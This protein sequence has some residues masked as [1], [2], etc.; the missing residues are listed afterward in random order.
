M[1]WIF[2]G[3]VFGQNV[4]VTV[5]GRVTEAESGQPISNF[6]I[7]IGQPAGF[8]DIL[9]FRSAFTDASG[10]YS[11]NF[12]G[13][14]GFPLK[15]WTD[16][17]RY[18]AYAWPNARFHYDGPEGTAGSFAFTHGQNIPLGAGSPISG[19]DF[20]VT[21]PA[22]LTGRVISQG[23]P[24]A[25]A[26]V[27]IRTG[28]FPNAAI[29]GVS[30]NADGRFSLRRMHPGTGPLEVTK[31]GFLNT[32]Y[33]NARLDGL[34]QLAA[35]QPPQE[36]TL[37]PE[38]ELD[39]ELLVDPGYKLQVSGT[40][41][42]VAVPIN[43]QIRG[44]DPVLGPRPV[45]D[46]ILAYGLDYFIYN[47]ESSSFR[48]VAYP[49][50]P[51]VD[52]P[53]NGIQPF[54]LANGSSPPDIVL[55]LIARQLLHGT[56]RDAAG[57]PLP[58]ARVSRAARFL[59]GFSGNVVRL[60]SVSVVTD[61]L[62]RYQLPGLAPGTSLVAA[63]SPPQLAWATTLFP[64]VPCMPLAVCDTAGGTPVQM[65][66]DQD[67][68]GA[69]LTFTQAGARSL[70]RAA[71]ARP[72]QS[73]EQVRVTFLDGFNSYIRVQQSGQV[74]ELAG[75]VVPPATTADVFLELIRP[76]LGRVAIS[77]NGTMFRGERAGAFSPQP[78]PAGVRTVDFGNVDPDEFLFASGF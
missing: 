38:Q 43:A 17:Q 26:W 57:L 59:S 31:P 36:L 77:S 58:G 52:W 56:V 64:N 16:D 8:G 47:P 30:T 41:L 50:V 24:L 2:A 40:S 71:L 29:A 12:T 6:R 49:D 27:G 37:Q 35:G 76:E 48:G 3:S 75:D 34:G 55:P 9:N 20:A 21:R 72:L 54:R 67:R 28:S 78:L 33:P 60:D 39:I 13:S 4:Q 25:G 62:G 15:I 63:V 70:G 53:C 19:I 32:R 68:F 61:A 10:N 66:L 14:S 44:S 5:S 11:I 74:V 22:V 42:G 51:C 46:L 23:K 18:P 1:L 73:G 45:S 7:G 65:T 69:D